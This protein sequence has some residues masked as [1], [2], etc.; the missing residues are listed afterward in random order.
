M[1]VRQKI[2]PSDF[3]YCMIASHWDQDKKK[4]KKTYFQVGDVG[5]TQSVSSDSRYS[6][7]FTFQLFEKAFMIAIVATLPLI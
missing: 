3:N 1:K 4:P 5:S 2:M 6:H 7:N